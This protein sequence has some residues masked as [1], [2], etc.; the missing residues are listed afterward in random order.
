MTLYGSSLVII[1]GLYERMIATAEK[2]EAQ[3]I[4]LAKDGT[5][6]TDALTD[7]V[8]G[9]SETVKELRRQEDRR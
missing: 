2:R 7:S 5:R 1:R 6:A 4:E 9:L 3:A 8:K